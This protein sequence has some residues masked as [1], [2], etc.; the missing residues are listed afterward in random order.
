M[1]DLARRVLKGVE[2]LRR[3]DPD[4]SNFGA[5]SHRYQF[6][7]RATEGDV[8]S[9]ERRWGMRLPAD[10]RE[11]LLKVGNGGAGPFYGIFRLGEWDGAGEGE[12]WEASSLGDPSKPFPHRRSWNEPRS[13]ASAPSD[14]ESDEYHRWMDLEDGRYYAPA[15]TNGSIPICTEGCALRFLLVVTGP[16]AGQVWYDARADE[17]G[18]M[19]MGEGQNRLSFSEWYLAWLDNALYESAHR[20]TTAKRSRS[21]APRS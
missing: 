4:L 21:K 16:E 7:P 3:F 17:K 12:P 11:F 10:Y 5:S 20:R 8:E 2:E 19:P 6:N 1:D 15:L 14:Q 13:Y 18:L 9:C